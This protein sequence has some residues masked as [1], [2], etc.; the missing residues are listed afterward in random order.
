[1]IV[2][3]TGGIGSALVQEYARRKWQVGLLGRDA[4]KIRTTSDVL[5]TE[6]PSGGFPFEVCDVRDSKALPV[7][8]HALR[9][10]LGALDLLIYAGGVMSGDVNDPPDFAAEEEMFAVNTL[11]AVHVLGLAADVMRKQRAGHLAAIGSIAGE[12][13]RKGNPAYCASK[14]ALHTYLEGLRN[15]LHPFG[16]RVSTIKPGFVNTRMLRGQRYPGA[17]S[18]DD[19][20][21]R[22]AAALER[23][24]Q[25]FFVPFWWGGVALAIRAC[26]SAIF[27]RFGPP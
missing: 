3:A 14:A 12:R 16:V 6:Y 5:R 13:G 27:K 7:A 22:I 1:M 24:S 8:F 26:P 18:A 4:G 21:G 2:G 23:R 25:S 20:A 17:I 15:R 9:E 10:R 19:A 11:G